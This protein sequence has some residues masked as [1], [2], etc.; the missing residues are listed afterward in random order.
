MDW[1]D[2]IDVDP[3]LCQGRPCV[4][5][6]QIMVLVNLDNPSEAGSYDESPESNPSSCRQDMDGSIRYVAELVL[7]RVATLA[8]GAD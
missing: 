1:H 7:E 8:R 6:T 4:E 3:M 2:R 5:G